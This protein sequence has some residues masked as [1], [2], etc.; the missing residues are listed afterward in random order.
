MDPRPIQEK[1]GGSD[2]S[3]VPGGST[4]TESHARHTSSR[5]IQLNLRSG[6]R[7][8]CH[9]CSSNAVCVMNP[10]F[11]L[12]PPPRR[13]KQRLQDRIRRSD[14]PPFR[15]CRDESGAT[16][17]PPGGSGETPGDSALKGPRGP[18]GGGKTRPS[19]LR[20][21][22]VIRIS[23]QRTPM[24]PDVAGADWARHSPLSNANNDTP[25]PLGGLTEQ[26]LTRDPWAA[27]PP[28]GTRSLEIAPKNR[29][30]TQLTI[31]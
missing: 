22:P 27:S 17:P 31:P 26:G 5:G 21:T 15:K 10:K 23:R 16:T 13:R 18:G 30:E 8:P 11:G 6:W 29:P 28:P 14:P 12:Q 20:I 4:T 24:K 1:E 19:T 2:S 3:P 25:S 9:T 7:L